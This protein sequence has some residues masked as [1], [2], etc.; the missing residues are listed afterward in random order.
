MRAFN[1]FVVFVV[2]GFPVLCTAAEPTVSTTSTAV[3][4][5]GELDDMVQD[6]QK[7]GLRGYLGNIRKWARDPKVSYDR[8]TAEYDC[9]FGVMGY[10]VTTLKEL[11][12]SQAELIQLL[13]IRRKIT[14]AHERRKAW[15]RDRMVDSYLFR[16]KWK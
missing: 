3:T 1:L 16:G 6:A 13:Q 7:G 15:M 14:P 5:Q 4:T 12:T 2:L 8:F 10:T 9:F 11:G